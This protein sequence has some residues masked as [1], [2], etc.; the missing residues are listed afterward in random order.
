LEYG[1]LLVVN[2]EL[3]ARFSPKMRKMQH[4]I[5]S[6]AKCFMLLQH[7]FG[8]SCSSS[9]FEILVQTTAWPN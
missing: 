5:E 1:D 4:E 2:P 3:A 8:F 6:A 7:F 9:Y